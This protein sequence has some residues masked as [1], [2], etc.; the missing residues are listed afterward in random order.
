MKS[1]QK[2]NGCHEPDCH[3]LFGI[4]ADLLCNVAT[5]WYTGCIIIHIASQI[6]YVSRHL[7]DR[8]IQ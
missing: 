3:S 6:V 7:T 8:L 1:F 5:K 4:N 2:N